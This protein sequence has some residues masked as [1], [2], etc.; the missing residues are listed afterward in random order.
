MPRLRSWMSALAAAALASSLGCG[1]P[2][3][4][5]ST[6]PADGETWANP[7]WP[8]LVTFSGPMRPESLR[9]SST[10]EVAALPPSWNEE[11]L[12]V[13]LAPAAPLPY[14]TAF[15]VSGAASGDSGDEVTFQFAFVT[16]EDRDAPMVVA[17]SPEQDATGVAPDANIAI[18]FSEPMAPTSTRGFSFYP[19]L[20]C[21]FSSD[22]DGARLS[23]DPLVPLV[24]FKRYV[25]GI[26]S[27]ATDLKGNP[28]GTWV[29]RFTT[30][31]SSDATPPLVAGST[32]ADGATGVSALSSIQV[33]FSEAMDTASVQAAFAVTSPAGYE[34]SVCRWNAT[35][36]VAS[37]SLSPFPVGATVSWRVGTGARDMAGNSLAQAFTASFQVSGY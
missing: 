30:G 20:D 18:Q 28:L 31:A 6:L 35:Q 5:V 25:L 7:R 13:T 32:P 12:T 22:L 21:A 19:D 26:D 24:P 1:P 33:Q 27:Q 23:C 10:P 17:S 29:L 36:T 8:W 11:R 34:R 37:C 3:A 15:E 2:V 9:W 16:R 14:A 4:L